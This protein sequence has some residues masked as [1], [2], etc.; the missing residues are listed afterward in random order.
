MAL[1]LQSKLIVADE[2]VTTLDVLVQK[3]ILDLLLQ[4]RASAGISIVLV[5][6]DIGVVSYV[7]DRV[8]VMYAGQAVEQGRAEN[9]LALPVHPYDGAS[10]G[11]PS[12]GGLPARSGVHRGL[13]ARSSIY[14]RVGV[15]VAAHR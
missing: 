9:V 14:L 7:C 10:A 8:V 15:S 4:L 3:Q 5:T 6:H 1:A 12:S 13:S 2:P 11:H